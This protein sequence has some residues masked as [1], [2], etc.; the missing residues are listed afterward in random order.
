MEDY[1]KKETC[2]IR[3]RE[4]PKRQ[5][6]SFKGPKSK[7]YRVA[8]KLISLLQKGELRE[9]KVKEKAEELMKS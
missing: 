4:Y 5:I 3:Q 8:N 6:A 1:R 9:D 2:G 7:R